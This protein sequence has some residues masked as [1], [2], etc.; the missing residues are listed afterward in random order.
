[1][2]WNGRRFLAIAALW[3]IAAAVMH[4]ANIKGRVNVAGKSAT[5]RAEHGERAVVWLTPL[6]G[7]SSSSAEGPRNPP[8]RLTRVQQNKRFEPHVMVVQVGATV[9]FPNRDPFFHNVFSLFEGKRFDL[10]LYEAGSTRSVRF[11]RPGISYIFCNIHP[12]MSTVVITLDTPYFAVSNPSGEFEI[13]QV[14]PGRYRM[15]IWAERCLPKTLKDL[16]REVT[17]SEQGAFLGTIHLEESREF[18][19]IRLNKYGK[20]YD[21]QV[22]SS[23]IYR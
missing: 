17:V 3:L 5:L 11:D 22:F 8:R 13:S 2:N 9:D 10:G 16:S 15:D 21:P 23:P 7:A 19:Q 20:S 12:Q 6:A 1:M 4:G 14:P 18:A